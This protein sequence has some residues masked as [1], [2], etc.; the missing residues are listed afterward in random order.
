M[1]VHRLFSTPLFLLTCNG[2]LVSVFTV[3]NP[4]QP[5]ASLNGTRIA[6]NDTLITSTIEYNGE[7]WTAYEDL[8]RIDGGLYFVSTS[9]KIRNFTRYLEQSYDPLPGE[10]SVDFFLGL[11]WSEVN[12]ALPDLLA[13]AL[14]KDGEPV[15][16]HVR[17][18]VPQVIFQTYQSFLGN[19]QANDS[20]FV[21][22]Y[23]GTNNIAPLNGLPIVS[24]SY[25]NFTYDGL[26]GGWMPI[27]RK[28][29][30]LSPDANNW[31]EVIV[32]G[33][34]DSAEPF[35]TK[36]WFRSTLV[37]NG[38]A[39][40]QQFS[41][42]Y[43]A[44]PPM[45]PNP[46]PE[47]FY[48]AL[49]RSGDYWNGY[50]EDVS[51]LNLPDQSWADMTKHSF[52]IE[53]IVRYGG[54]Y[55]KYGFYDRNYA[56]SEYD[57]FQDIFTSSVMANLLWGRFDQAK[58]VIENYFTWFVSDTG[59]INM[60]GVE[61]PQFGISLSLLAIYERYTGNTA[62]LT[63]WKSKILAWVNILEILHDESLALEKTNLNYGLIAGFSESDS[64]LSRDSGL[65]VS[66]YWNNN[67]NAARGLKDLSTI[68]I[69][70][71]FSAV[72]AAR[73]ETMINQTVATLSSVIN[74]NMNPPYV[75]VLP[76]T[77]QTVRECM[78]GSV[79][80]QQMWSHRVYSE[81]L[82]PGILPS[83]LANLTINSMRANGITSLGVVANVGQIS[84]DSRDILGFIS[85][86]YAQALLLLDRIDEFILFLYSHRYHV[87]S[88]GQWIATEVAGTYG[89]A[90]DENPF[91]VPAAMTIPILMRI[92]LVF[93]HPDDDVLYV[94]RGV[95]SAWLE[96]GKEVSIKQAPT[97]WGWVDFAIQAE[98]ATGIVRVAVS[99][100]ENP[101]KELRLKIRLP[102]NLDIDVL[103]I[104]NRTMVPFVGDELV[105]DT[106]MFGKSLTVLGHFK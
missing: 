9:G 89:G 7:P 15:E 90:G 49:L 31:L 42:E 80:C 101:P 48:A 1:V 44:Y 56:G 39:Q 13:D 78:Q 87:H 45:R 61:I 8:T 73:A 84:P 104:N 68:S 50:L 75:P 21:D 36:S 82:Q 25:W 54:K 22:K 72:W 17:D 94:G 20:M 14:L 66:P 85:Y 32:F 3:S 106:S 65:Y 91:C 60:R 37:I 74:Y 6:S 95:P 10:G 59:D 51:P 33:D 2:A 11:D 16:F 71:D 79:P 93:E 27:I 47:E 35:I 81:M 83:D 46:K 57:G 52:A 62:L 55:P 97:R 28:V 77:T 53:L 63:K 70:S 4:T 67:A 43:P 24:N 19:V 5:Q 103:T 30:R 18:A 76:N 12:L 105:L 26:V 58:D 41:R 102:K 29:F 34:A 40:H 88:R 92:A 86:G 100:T 98:M 64:V 99:F 96:T 69:F 23:G 38:K